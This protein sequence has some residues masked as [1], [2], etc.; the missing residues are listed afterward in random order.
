MDLAQRWRFLKGYVRQPHV[1]GAVAPSSTALASAL[2]EPFH[3]YPRPARVLEVGA[4]TGAITR[5]LGAILGDRDELDVCEIKPEFADILRRDVLSR[6][7]FASGVSSG[8]VRLVESA[9]Q[10]LPHEDRYDF[11]ISCLPL[12]AFELREVREV[13]TVLRRCLKPG[14]VLSYFEYMA[15]RRGSAVFSLGRRRKRIRS[16]S[17][18]LTSTIKKFQF[19]RRAVLANFPPANT[20]FLR[21]DSEGS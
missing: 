16:V 6:P 2:C 15:F 12:N 7:D 17:A 8:R 9:V 19:R 21:F 14:G 10:S 5:H 11:V 1:V 13:F 4:G 18:Y 3:R 20:R